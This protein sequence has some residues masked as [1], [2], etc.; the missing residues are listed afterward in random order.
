MQFL[1]NFFRRIQMTKLS[2]RLQALALSGALLISPLAFAT[3]D[4]SDSTSDAMDQSQTTNPA[5]STSTPS[6]A[7]PSTQAGQMG[8]PMNKAALKQHRK[9]LKAQQKIE[10]NNL[11]QKHKAEKQAMKQKH[12]DQ[13]AALN[14]GIA[15]QSAAQIN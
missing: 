2:L 5:S 6:T 10:K 15:P 14:S 7:V 12:N 3:D 8:Q 13:H 1:Y 11:K 9:N 4:S